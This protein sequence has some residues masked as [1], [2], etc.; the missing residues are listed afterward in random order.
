MRIAVVTDAWYPQRNGVVRVLESLKRRTEAAGHEVLVVSPDQFRTI[1]CP[2]YSEIR[3]ALAPSRKASARLDAFAPHAIHIATEGPL[4]L[5]ARAYCLARS[6]PFTTAYHTKFPQYLHARTRLPLAWLYA[7]IR[8]FHAPARH[9][10]VP[11]P[12]VA[13][14]LTEVGFANLRPWIHGV[15]TE[16]FRPRGKAALNFP[17]PIFMYVGR[18]TIDKNLPAFLELDLPGTKVVVGSGP[19]RDSLMRRYPDVRF[20]IADGDEE[21]A[22]LYSAA[23]AF[24]FP[25]RTDTFGLVMLEALAAGVPVAAFPVAG[26][27]DVIGDSNAG[28]LDEDLRAAALA[29][30]SIS[31][32]LCRAHAARF[33]WDRATEEFLS[34]LA[35]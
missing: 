18:V 28:I 11:S 32:D 15:D 26:P 22:R 25:S 4:G 9:V 19:S 29:A 2:S 5:A 17:R 34:A 33:S 30:L 10:L 20:L 27:L 35:V 21:L 31:P 8:R 6:R 23:D 16:L 14:E 1:P 3:L 7:A 12:S 24:V 13:R